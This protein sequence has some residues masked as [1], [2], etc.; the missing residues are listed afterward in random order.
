MFF[1]LKDENPTERKPILTLGL[2]LANVVIF[3]F[4][5]LQGSDFYVQIINSYG[6]VP[7]EIATFQ[8][9]HTIFTSMFLHGGF[10]HLIGN[11]WFLWIFGD[12]IED[13]FGREKFLLIYF[14]T[15]V[16]ASLAHVAFSP[17][18]TV[19]TI[20]ASGAIAGVLGAYLMKYPR[21]KVLTLFFIFLFFTVIKVPSMVF[22]GVWIGLQLL[23]ASVTTVAGTKVSVAYW[24]HIGGFFAGMVMAYF[25]EER[26]SRPRE[27]ITKEYFGKGYR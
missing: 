7:K 20:G 4:S 2:I 16:A 9:L 26:I 25:L 21:A 12:N 8:N 10:I 14:G 15:G 22:L 17:S 19:P 5:Y 6:M 24:A 13:L 1:P 23:N 18:S 3:L 27:K 11:V